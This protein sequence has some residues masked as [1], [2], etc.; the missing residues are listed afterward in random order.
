MSSPFEF[1]LSR[2]ELLCR[3]GGGLGAVGLAHVLADAGLF[4]AAPPAGVRKPPVGHRAVGSNPL[5]PRP[6]HFAAKAKRLIFLFMNGGPSHVD[7]FD[8]KPALGTHAGKPLPESAL[9]K[10][11]RRLA[12]KLMPSPFSARKFGQS[13]IDAT[14]LYPE[15]GACID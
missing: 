13:G 3:I 12:G 2:R 8:P 5:A 9:K 11:G 14:E 10:S 1:G 15:V 6:P 4:A 7:T